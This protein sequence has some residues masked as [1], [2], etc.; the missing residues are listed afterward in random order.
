[1]AL[2][3]IL[4]GDLDG[5]TASEVEERYRRQ[6]RDDRGRDAAAGRTLS[7]PHR[8][9]LLV[10]H[11]PKDMPAETCSTG[12]QKALLIGLVLAQA[13]LVT[14]LSGETPL[15]LLDEIAAHLDETRREALFEVLDDL[16]AQA[17]MT[18]TDETVFAGLGDRIEIGRAR[19]GRIELEPA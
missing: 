15:I 19:D 1:V 7:G 16:G 5:F 3:G 14:S 4:E 8:S 2:A 17:F 9:D 10:R 6:L 13:R 11:A 12:E 18:G